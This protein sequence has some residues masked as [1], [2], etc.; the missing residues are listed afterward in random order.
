MKHTSIALAVTAALL[1][2]SGAQADE[3]SGAY[4]GA[5]VGSSR[6]DTSGAQPSSRASA[7]TYGLEGGYG[8]DLGK[9]TLGVDGFYDSNDQTYHATLGQLGSH[10]YGL[11]LKL[12]LPINSLMPYAKLGYAHTTGTGV[13]NGNTFGSANSMNG[14]LGLEYKFAPNWSVAGEW[15]TLS[16]SSNGTKLN[17][18]NFSIGVNY[19]F[20]P[21][22]A[23][24]A[25]AAAEPAPAPA[26]AE[27]APQPKEAWKV[28]ME[29]KPVRIEGASFDTN[30]AKLKPTADA[31][32]QQVVDFAKQYPDANLQV[33]GYTDSRGSK[34]YNLKLSQ[35]RADAVK[36]YLVKKGIAADRI[37]TQGHGMDN[38]VADN[39]T[40]AG[41]AQNRRVEV[42]YTVREEK[43]VRVQ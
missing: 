19:Y 22:P 15:T 40:A 34:P 13:L 31:K 30:S 20:A 21:P 41:R 32:L 5:K 12:G 14:G 37:S 26:A 11:G 10:V 17:N 42:H 33:D 29:E 39:K 7:T 4:V 36:A 8:W 2:V 1:A 18:D 6:S 35:H 38:P 9:T 16:P 3:F 24:P 27:P 25:V 28:I 43:K 23:A